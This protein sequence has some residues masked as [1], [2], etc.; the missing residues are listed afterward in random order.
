[1]SSVPGVSAVTVLI[2]PWIVE[3]GVRNLVS[4]DEVESFIR[5]LSNNLELFDD[6]VRQQQESIQRDIGIR[7]S[8]TIQ[9]E[10][11]LNYT[12][13]TSQ[14]SVNLYSQFCYMYIE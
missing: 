4:D 10:D 2:I 14:Y 11:Q 12:E 1:M 13:T 8:D 6:T 5:N 7:L 3:D 9:Q